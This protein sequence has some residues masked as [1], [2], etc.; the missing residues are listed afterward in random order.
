MKALSRELQKLGLSDKEALV[1]LAS[2]EL[3]PSPVQV[4]SRKAEVNRATTYVMIEALL[5]KGLM[6]TFDKGKKTLYT[7]EKP[8]RLHRIV[9]AERASVDE[10]ESVI[11]RLLPDLDAI[12]DAAGDRP[13]VSFYEGEEGFEAMRETIFSQKVEEMEDVISYDDLNHLL[14]QSH[15]KKHSERL[16]NKKI[17][18]R[19][20]FTSES[21]RKPTTD[22]GGLWQY[23]QLPHKLFPM[24]G[25][26]TVYGNHVA[27]VALRGKIVGVIIE[28]KEMA[29]MVRTLFELAWKQADSYT[30]K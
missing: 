25:E 11:K 5:Q 10:K 1:Y 8:E 23:K 4:I 18:G 22:H 29:T 20:L 15:W 17:K 7:A 13:K 14:D 30:N 3:G 24:H 12:S 9:H 19:A 2:L 27:M 16:K 28:S 26:L 6:S 21:G